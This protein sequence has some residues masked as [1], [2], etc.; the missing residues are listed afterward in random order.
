M[1]TGADTRNGSSDLDLERFQDL[2]QAAE[3]GLTPTVIEG[4]VAYRDLMRAWNV[5]VRLVSRS[6]GS[7]ILERHVYESLLLARFLPASATRLVDIGT[8][9]GLPGIPLKIFRPD[10]QV[11]LLDSTRMKT[12]FL[13]EVIRTLSLK[14]IEVVHDRAERAVSS[15]GGTFDLA[16]SRAVATLDR[17]WA[18]AQPLLRADGSMLSL[19][20]PGEAEKELSG[21]GLDF[22]EHV[23]ESKYRRVSVVCIKQPQ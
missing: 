16:T 17:V 14:G 20:G 5:R 21:A 3:I 2:C 9:G 8:G 10:L 23:F 13:R 22:K 12:L 7:R 15:I 1:T 19:K 18:F 6:N 4:L 11:V